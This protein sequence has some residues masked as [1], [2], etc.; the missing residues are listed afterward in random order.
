MMNPKPADCSAQTIGPLP[1]HLEL[2]DYLKSE[3]CDLW[4]WFASAQVQAEYRENLRMELLKSC[5]R[6][7]GASHPGL[8][9]MVEDVKRGLQIDVPVTV[10]Q[11]QNSPLPNAALHFIPGEGHVVFSG[12]VL[13][14]LTPD[15][16]KAILGHELAHYRLWEWDQ[17]ELHIVDR[18][19]QAAACDPRAGASHEQT[20]RRFQLYTEIF[21]DRGALRVTGDLDCVVAA[22]VKVETGLTQVSAPAYLQQAEEIFAR[23]GVVTEGVS[24][25][26]AFIRARALSL[27]Q[28]QGDDAQPAIAKMIEGPGTLDSLDLLGQLRLAGRTRRFLQDL[29]GPKWFQTPAVLGHARLFFPDFGLGDGNEALSPDVL[30]TEDD[31]TREYFCYVLLDFVTADPELDEMPLAAALEMSRRLGFDAQFEKLAAK[32]LKLKVRD[33]RKLKEQAAEM[34]AQAEVPK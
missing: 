9:P 1:Y 30:G 3:E 2:R 8:L 17:G 31:R 27:W 7:E 11:A 20:A 25:P 12:P 18:L 15:E 6:L 19:L 34:L 13:N 29:L 5:Y 33:L 21:A 16:T 26:E 24:H 23:D 22:L 10:Y 14:L 28:E 32:E 4:R